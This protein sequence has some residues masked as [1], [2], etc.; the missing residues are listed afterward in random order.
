MKTLFISQ[1]TEYEAGWGSKPDG[2]LIGKT[3]EAMLAEIERITKD[4]SYQIFWRYTEPKETM[5][6][7]ETYDKIDALMAEIAQRCGKDRGLIEVSNG[8][9]SKYNFYKKI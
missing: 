1:C 2:V 4:E 5:C 9:F 3:K 6:D 8:E 7:D